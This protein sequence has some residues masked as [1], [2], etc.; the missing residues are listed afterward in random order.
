MKV[1]AVICAE[2]A[3]GSVNSQAI[4]QGAIS[5][6]QTVQPPQAQIQKGRHHHHHYCHRQS[7]LMQFA[8]EVQV[9]TWWAVQRPVWC[10]RVLE[11]A[12][13]LGCHQWM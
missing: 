10:L 13:L 8:V 5:C 4:I 3:Y 1:P 11:L 9:L 7:A 6:P 12:Q 2:H